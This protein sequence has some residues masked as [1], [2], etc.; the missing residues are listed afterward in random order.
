MTYIIAL[1][2]FILDLASKYYVEA[3]T[4]LHGLEIIP[5][6]FYITYLK[7]T[8]MAWSLL[9]NQTL[10]LTIVSIVVV[11]FILYYL[12]TNKLTK[13]YKVIFGLILGGALGNLFDRIVYQY[14]RDFLD[15]YIFG[16]NFPV[17]NIADSA[18][19]IGIILLLI[20][21]IL[22]EIHDKTK[23]DS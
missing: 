14:V 9:S 10:L 8:G 22:E 3:N 20:E 17:F 11:I 12:K 15:F 5:D 4:S 19:T 21:F 23:V 2:V 1:I 16:Y 18:L 6:F 13:M 7:N